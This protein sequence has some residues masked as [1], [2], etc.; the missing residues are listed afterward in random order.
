MNTIEAKHIQKNFIDDPNVKL[1]D[2]LS[3]GGKRIVVFDDLSF[4]VKKGELLGVIGKNGV[5][6]STLLRTIGGVYNVDK[7]NVITQGTM[8]SIFELG[9]FY[10]QELTG[11]QY[12][13]DYFKFK[14]IVKDVDKLIESIHD[15]TELGEYFF[16]PTR[17]YSSG[18]RAKL[19]F[20]T[21]TALPA[22]V[23]L[24]DEILVVGDEYFAAN[25][26]FPRK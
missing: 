25:A 6:K 17:T 15:F 3:D 1:R 4:E 20:G 18:M 10:N 8:A 19:L 11:I 14:G 7:G 13:K 24:I 22:D 16:E 23:I 12:C 5:G 26:R 21:A 2:I 9:S